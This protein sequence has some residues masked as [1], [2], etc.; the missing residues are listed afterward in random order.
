MRARRG[1]GGRIRQMQ[2]LLSLSRIPVLF[3][4]DCTRIVDQHFQM[5]T[6]SGKCQKKQEYLERPANIQTHHHETYPDWFKQDELSILVGQVQRHT[7]Q[8][9]GQLCFYCLVGTCN[10][11]T[12]LCWKEISLLSITNK[13]R[14]STSILIQ[15]RIKGEKNSKRRL[16]PQRIFFTFVYLSS[17]ITSP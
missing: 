12:D 7:S 17:L 6:G 9:Q 1:R 16:F 4:I 13:N 5:F 14:R 11:V 8:C 15:R 10:K 3:L 2:A